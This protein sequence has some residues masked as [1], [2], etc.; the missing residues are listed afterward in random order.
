MMCPSY[1]AGAATLEI[2]R[3]GS[4]GMVKFHESP[5]VCRPA[6]SVRRAQVRTQ[7]VDDGR[8]AGPCVTAA[9]IN[10]EGSCRLGRTVSS[11]ASE[12]GQPCAISA[13]CRWYAENGVVACHGCRLVVYVE[14]A[15]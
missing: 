4:D 15:G 7:V 12:G 9:C 14:T 8:F 10:W 5:V 11:R 6:E 2:G 3:R 1:P 13:E